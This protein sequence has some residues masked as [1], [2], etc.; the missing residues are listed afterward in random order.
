[1]GLIAPTKLVQ[2]TTPPGHTLKMPILYRQNTEE[3]IFEHDAF[4]LYTWNVFFSN[5][6]RRKAFRLMW[7]SNLYYHTQPDFRPHPFLV[8]IIQ[9]SWRRIDFLLWCFHFIYLECILS[10][11]N[12][13]DLLSNMLSVPL[14]GRFGTKSE[15]GIRCGFKALLL[16]PCTASCWILAYFCRWGT[17]W[18]RT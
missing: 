12:C 10:Y 3:S 6:N 4:T 5:I 8:I 15:K 16:P 14:S 18:T 7:V 1:M 11:I 13:L 9:V 17:M 2:V